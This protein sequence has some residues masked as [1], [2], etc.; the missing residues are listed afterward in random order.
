MKQVIKEIA[1][2]LECSVK[3]LWELFL[4]LVICQNVFGGSVCLQFIWKKIPLQEKVFLTVDIFYEAN[5]RTGLTN[6][7]YFAV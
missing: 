5:W 3:I 7:L 6:R 2:I 4:G 1:T